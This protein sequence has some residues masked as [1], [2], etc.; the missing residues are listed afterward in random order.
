M[1]PQTAAALQAMNVVLSGLTTALGKLNRGVGTATNFTGNITGINNFTQ[2]INRAG[3]RFT[4]DLLRVFGPLIAFGTLLSAATSGFN[5]FTGAIK[6]AATATGALLLPLFTVFA[7]AVLTFVDLLMQPEMFG[8][9]ESY[10]HLVISTALSMADS[11]K[12]TAT[13]VKE[14]GLGLKAILDFINGVD[15]GAKTDSEANQVEAERQRVKAMQETEHKGFFDWMKQAGI[16]ERRT[17][18]DGKTAVKQ[19]GKWFSPTEEQQKMIELHD[20]RMKQLEDEFKGIGAEFAEEMYKRRN[21]QPANPN[22]STAP[23]T[24]AELDAIISGE[25]AA[26][27]DGNRDFMGPS[28]DPVELQR[29]EQAAGKEKPG[30]FG[31]AMRKNLGEVM[32]QMR[33]ENA[34][35][36]QSFSLAAVSKQAQLAALNQSPFEV[37][38]QAMTQRIIGLMEKVV[39]NQDRDRGQMPPATE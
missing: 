39:A 21:A 12:L 33:F 10:F 19:D 3:N 28:I 30:D 11:L 35:K 36:P 24:V 29:R 26:R 27:Q 31:A 16:Q 8:A 2:A 23:K 17:Y 14:F 5:L 7:A 38:M 20:K 34:P 32:Q 18:D 13:Q 9:M 4:G 25:R 37:K 22:W 1:N 15:P 6:V